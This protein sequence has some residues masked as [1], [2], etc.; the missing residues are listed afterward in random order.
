MPECSVTAAMLT[1]VVTELV[2]QTGKLPV[3]GHLIHIFGTTLGVQSLHPDASPVDGRRFPC[4]C[5]LHEAPCCFNPGSSIGF[6]APQE[7]SLVAPL[8]NS[9]G[10]TLGDAVVLSPNHSVGFQPK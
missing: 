5:R 6:Y 8:H 1:L 2:H 3:F 10:P 4:D 9:L 7:A